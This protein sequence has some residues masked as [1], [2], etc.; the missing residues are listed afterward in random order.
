MVRQD[1]TRSSKQEK[2][3][4]DRSIDRSITASI[5][6]DAAPRDENSRAESAQRRPRRNRTRQRTARA[7][8]PHQRDSNCRRWFYWATARQQPR[9][10][11]RPQDDGTTVWKTANSVH[12]RVR[13]ASLPDPVVHAHPDDDVVGGDIAHAPLS[14]LSQHLH[15]LGQV[16]RTNRAAVAADFLELGH[17]LFLGGGFRLHKPSGGAPAPGGMPE[18]LFEQFCDVFACTVTITSIL[19]DFPSVGERTPHL[20]PPEY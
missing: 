12:I 15:R 17:Q 2:W 16:A 4:Y 14:C 5:E 18:R 8:K 9:P 13:P 7:N 10:R 6:I 19:C 20:A 3:C 11:P 1:K